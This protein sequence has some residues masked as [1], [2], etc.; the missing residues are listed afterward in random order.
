M[1]DFLMRCANAATILAIAVMA[2]MCLML[3]FPR[4]GLQKSTFENGFSQAKSSQTVSLIMAVVAWF[5]ISGQ[6]RAN[7]IKGYAKLS[8]M[9]SNIGNAWIVLALLTLVLG[10]LM[11]FAKRS[12]DD[13]NEMRSILK[14]CFIQGTIYLIISFL[15]DVG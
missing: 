9:C 4:L 14:S 7:C 12:T 5:L 11:S 10:I 6:A 2:V 13:L 3:T 15:L 1:I 8:A